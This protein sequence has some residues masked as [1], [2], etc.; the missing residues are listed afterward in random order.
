[1]ITSV[2]SVIE[3]PV[4][5]V[6]RLVSDFTSWESWIP[7]ESKFTMEDGFEQAPVG[8]VRLVRAAQGPI[9]REKLLAKDVAHHT[10]TYAFDGPTSLPVRRYVS[11]MRLFD[12]SG[13]GSTFI[14]WSAQMDTDADQ[15]ELADSVISGIY[16]AFMDAL[17]THLAGG[18]G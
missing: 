18:N 7:T 17:R 16:V 8:S 9:I 13:T 11:T 14:H 6:W 12:I 4:E 5:D 2:G 15:E 1:M 3:A 10:M